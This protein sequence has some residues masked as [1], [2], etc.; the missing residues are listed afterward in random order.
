MGVCFVIS[1]LFRASQGSQCEC[2][3]V[4]CPRESPSS[5]CHSQLVLCVRLS[6]SRASVSAA[7]SSCR[8]DRSLAA[9]E[10]SIPF[11]FI[12][13]I[14]C[15]TIISASSSWSSPLQAEL[16]RPRD[17]AVSS[18][19]PQPARLARLAKLKPPTGDSNC[20]LSQA[21]IEIEAE[22]VTEVA[23]CGRNADRIGQWPPVGLRVTPAAH[24]HEHSPHSPYRR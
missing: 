7:T 18:L 3:R 17:S 22:R 12:H 14:A 6:P 2:R 20:R 10:S 21:E 24:L 9:A 8:R 15:L 4:W 11:A 5:S 23:V 19:A 13:H 1:E 16:S